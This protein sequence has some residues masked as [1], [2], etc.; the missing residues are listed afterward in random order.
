MGY[1]IRQLEPET[2]ISE[3]LSLEAITRVVPMAKIEAT[4]RE[5]SVEGHR[6]RRLPGWLTVLMCIGMKLLSA[7]S[8]TGVME[9]LMRGTRL[10]HPS[11]E[12]AAQARRALHPNASA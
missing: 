6:N 8:M 1:S 12:E 7:L 3:M 2:K 11:D 5:C 10:I 9:H 4:L